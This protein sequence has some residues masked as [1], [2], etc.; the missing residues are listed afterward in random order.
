MNAKEFMRLIKIFADNPT[1][2][3]QSRDC[4]ILQVRDEVISIEIA[5]KD[6]NLYVK[7]NDSEQRAETWIVNRLARIPQLA[8]RLFDYTPQEEHFINPKGNLLDQL[9]LDPSETATEQDNAAKTITEV[10]D[11]RP[12]FC[13]NVLYLTSD[14]GEGKTTLINYIAKQQAQAYKEKR[15]NWLLIPI[16]LSGRPFLRFDDIVV[17]SLV[18]N[19]RFPFLF[20]DTFIELVK[21]GILIPA[22]DGFEE[23]FVESSTGEAL[24]ALGSLLNALDSSGTMLVSARKAYFDYKSLASQAKLLDT[25][26]ADNVAFARLALTRWRRAEFIQYGLKRKIPV[27]DQIYDNIASKLDQAHPI[28]TRAVLVKRLFDVVETKDDYNDL[29]TTLGDSPNEFFSNFVDA[30]IQREVKEKWIDK[31]GEPTQPLLT[32]QEHHAILSLIAQ[33]M[34]LSNTESLKSGILDLLAELFTEQINKDPRIGLQ[35]KERLKQHA[36]LVKS[37]LKRDEFS[38]D[39]DEFRQYF[40]GESLAARILANDVTDTKSI[41]RISTLPGQTAYAAAHT[42]KGSDKPVLHIIQFLNILSRAEGPIS[43]IR[44]NCGFLVSL[45]L[46]GKDRDH[47]KLDGIYLPIDALLCRQLINIE[48]NNCY[49]KATALDHSTL[50]NCTIASSKMERLS[51]GGSATLDRVNIID[52]NIECLHLQDRDIEIF[53]PEMIKTMLIYQGIQVS[54][55]EHVVTEAIVEWKAD[56]DLDLTE[57]VLRRFI[58]STQMNENIF[59]LRLGNSAKHFLEIVLPILLKHNILMDVR[60]LGGGKQRRFK[61][62]VPLEKVYSALSTSQGK[63]EAFLSHFE[64]KENDGH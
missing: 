57:K 3:E 62:G 34:W 63:F 59:K 61:L 19:Y 54:T 9:E 64:I 52:T 28:L 43:Y 51:I 58:R 42:I 13:S 21:M 17:A 1:A 20:W 50:T 41:L 40:L 33:E 45:L 56:E 39:H 16:L 15:S 8:E 27:P 37:P 48:F 24:S 14:A 2:V 26:H 22:F 46:D 31:M 60:Y 32:L 7:E 55:H 30:I 38:F 10:L 36:L 18:N 12:A 44:E 6:M 49:F 5:V 53:D 29:V 47:L 11:R 4:M 23:M 35:I 25:I